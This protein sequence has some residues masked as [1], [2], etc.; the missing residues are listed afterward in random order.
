MAFIGDGRLLLS[1]GMESDPAASEIPNLVLLDVSD[2]AASSAK[3]EDVR[4]LCDPRYLG[5]S[6][7][8]IA[9]EAGWSDPAEVIGQD[10]P[11]YPD[12]SQRVLALV[13]QDV[14][15]KI[16]GIC[17][18]RSETLLKLAKEQGKG[19]IEWDVWEG[20]TVRLDTDQV[21]GPRSL[22]KYSISGSR[23]VMVDTNETKGWAKIRMYDLSHWSRQHPSCARKPDG[24]KVQ[25]MVTEA[26]LE[27]PEDTRSICHAAMVQ[28]SVVFF[29]VSP[30]ALLF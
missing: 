23:F 25:C 13:F 7:K 30:L 28:D 29:S 24:E 17:V 21:S 3:S 15:D 22:S 8:V 26:S 2:P 18:V 20:F 10:V 9:E 27:L 12:P 1:E 14:D 11:F 4:F 16:Q 5:M 6:V 19:V